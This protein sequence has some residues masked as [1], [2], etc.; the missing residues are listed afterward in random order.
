[1]GG[2]ARGRPSAHHAKLSAHEHSIPA[3]EE[4]KK[5]AT[6]MDAAVKVSALDALVQSL[7]QRSHNAGFQGL[8]TAS[9]R[10]CAKSTPIESDPSCSY[11]NEED[12]HC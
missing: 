7:F 5:R 1:M 4:L 12:I 9:C 10:Q 6:Q 11:S 8:P 3:D 2:C